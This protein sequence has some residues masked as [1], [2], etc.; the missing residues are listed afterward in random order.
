VKWLGLTKDDGHIGQATG[1]LFPSSD[2]KSR[3]VQAPGS[4]H[5]R[6]TIIAILGALKMSMKSFGNKHPGK[7]ITNRY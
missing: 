4:F 1:P 6:E 3:L 5:S 7:D 2:L